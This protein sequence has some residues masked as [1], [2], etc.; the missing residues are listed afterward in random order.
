MKDSKKQ[1]I[2]FI[3]SCRASKEKELRNDKNYKKMFNLYLTY[4][5]NLIDIEFNHYINL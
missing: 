4:P 2:M 1:K 3:L 5:P